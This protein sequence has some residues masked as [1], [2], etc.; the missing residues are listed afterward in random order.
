MEFF[1]GLIIGFIGGILTYHF[2]KRNNPDL[3]DKVDEVTDDIEEV[4][5]GKKEKK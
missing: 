3:E 5:E 2:V 1:S 4:V